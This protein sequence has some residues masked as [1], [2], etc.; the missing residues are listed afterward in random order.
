VFDGQELCS[1][2]KFSKSEF[3]NDF[4]KPHCDDSFHECGA[5]IEMRGKEGSPPSLMSFLR[6]RRRRTF[7]NREL[8]LLDKTVPHMQRALLLHRRMLDLRLNNTMQTWALDQVQFGVVLL[9]GDG[10]VLF[11]NRAASELCVRLRGL[12]LSIRGLHA[13]APREEQGLQCA[14]RVA[15]SRSDQNAPTGIRIGANSGKNPLM[16]VVSRTGVP[17]FL[18]IS[19]DAVVAIFVTDPDKHQPGKA[20]LLA[21]LFGLTPAEVRLAQML[22][23]GSGLRDASEQL[24][25]AQ[26]TVR[27]QLKSIFAKTNVNRQSDLVRL[28]LKVPA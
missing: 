23:S 22:A 19:K 20:Q 10:K 27:S 18:A 8:H 17:D 28:V 3:Y 4:L 5:V 6:N 25:V 26:S 21:S 2:E 16:L 13:V 11:A 15:A 9:R 1:K 14:I 12:E 24:G 7:H